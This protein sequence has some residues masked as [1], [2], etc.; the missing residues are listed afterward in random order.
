MTSFDACIAD[1]SRTARAPAKYF[2]FLHFFIFSF[3]HFFISIKLPNFIKQPKML[4]WTLIGVRLLIPLKKNKNCQAHPRTREI[5]EMEDAIALTL[6]QLS[7]I[8]RSSWDEYH[9]L[10]LKET[11]LSGTQRSVVLTFDPPLRDTEQ[12]YAC[13]DRH[14]QLEDDW[15]PW[16]PES[17]F[18][19]CV[20]LPGG[21]KGP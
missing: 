8:G 10:L 7:K 16:W 3:F 13:V 15:P 11:V 6:E 21:P 2:F 18:R 19:S 12:Y 4:T 5:T 1:N 17:S 14:I 20:C 9:R